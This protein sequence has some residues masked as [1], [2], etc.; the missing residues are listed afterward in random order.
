MTYFKKTSL[1]K[2]VKRKIWKNQVF[3]HVIISSIH[4]YTILGVSQKQML[5]RFLKKTQ[6]K[7]QKNSND[8]TWEPVTSYIAMAYIDEL[9]V[10]FL[11]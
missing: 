9:F 8:Q 6:K 3:I 4:P 2:V 11:N 5:M 7:S 10:I 1:A